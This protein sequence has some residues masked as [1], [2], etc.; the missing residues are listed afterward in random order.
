MKRT[1]FSPTNSCAFK[2]LKTFAQSSFKCDGQQKW[3]NSS[4]FIWVWMS[5]EIFPAPPWTCHC[6]WQIFDPTSNTVQLF[7]Y[8]WPSVHTFH[9]QDCCLKLVDIKMYNHVHQHMCNLSTKI[10]LY[11]FALNL[12]FVLSVQNKYQVCL[13]HVKYGVRPLTENRKTERHVLSNSIQKK[14][15]K[16]KILTKHQ[17]WE[18]TKRI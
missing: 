6:A 5:F 7:S 13:C 4:K 10:Y 16:S 9:R 12:K 2:S 11:L 8:I 14:I 18:P 1:S 15:L 17:D 3:T